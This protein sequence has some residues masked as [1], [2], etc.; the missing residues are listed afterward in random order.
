MDTLRVAD[1]PTDGLWPLHE[2]IDGGLHDLNTKRA[3]YREW[4]VSAWFVDPGAGTVVRDGDAYASL[5]LP[6]FTG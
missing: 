3:L 4:G 2:L 5:Q 6:G 1:L